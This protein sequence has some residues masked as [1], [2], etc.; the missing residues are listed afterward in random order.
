MEDLAEPPAPVQNQI[1][2]FFK[3]LV[4][5]IPPTVFIR[6]RESWPEPEG[7][8]GDIEYRPLG[9]NKLC[10]EASGPARQQLLPLC[11]QI[12]SSLNDQRDEFTG[13]ASTADWSIALNLFMVG[14]SRDRASPVI[15]VCCSDDI[16]RKRA[17]KMIRDLGYLEHHAGV[18]LGK[19]AF[20]PIPVTGEDMT[21]VQQP[22]LSA[23]PYVVGEPNIAYTRPLVMNPC[24]ALIFVK[25]SSPS[26]GI[27]KATMGGVVLVNGQFYGITACHASDV[28]FANDHGI[29]SGNNAELS[30][31]DDDESSTNSKHRK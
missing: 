19:R 5:L 12:K 23:R 27:R 28:R 24:G 18:K 31:E 21:E 14:P 3:E 29:S 7:S 4:A 16:V 6:H 8:I 30:I 20:S 9:R 25:I 26:T 22:N 17:V 2:Q 13:G 11:R 1:K 10:W 15:I